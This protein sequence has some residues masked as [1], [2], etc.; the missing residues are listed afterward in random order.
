MAN[1][2]IVDDEKWICELISCSVPW[3]EMGMR[4]CAVAENGIEALEILK[5]QHIDI[6]ITDIRM[7][8]MDGIG[9]IKAARE[10]GYGGEFII[11]SG[12]QDFEYAQSAIKFN[13]RSYLVKPVDEEELIVLLYRIAMDLIENKRSEK[14]AEDV[15]ERLESTSK[16]IKEQL[17]RLLVK[18]ESAG[19][20]LGRVD[21]KRELGFAKSRCLC[22][23][24]QIDGPPGGGKTGA[25]RV[26]M[27]RLTERLGHM[28]STEGQL[29]ACYTDGTAATYILNTDDYG[30]TVDFLKNRLM[31]IKDISDAYPGY[32]LTIG[33]GNAVEGAAEI[34]SSHRSADAAV[35]YRLLAGANRVI[36]G[37]L[38]PLG[39]GAPGMNASMKKELR[40]L[41]EKM[42]F[43]GIKAFVHELFLSAGASALNPAALFELARELLLS[44]WEILSEMNYEPRAARSEV[45]KKIESASS[46]PLLAGYLEETVLTELDSFR[47]EKESELS[48]PVSLVK[49]YVEEN[50]NRPISLSDAAEHVF[51]NP[52]YLSRLFKAETGATFLDYLTGRRMEAAKALL[53]DGSVKPSKIPGLVGYIDARHYA[54]TFKKTVGLTPNEYRKL[55]T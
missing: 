6:V 44:L 27:N 2:M 42:D 54:K 12:Y 7:P 16:L 23:I 43:N 21:L 9:L 31:E 11:I 34:P 35:K 32:S 41:V 51:L 55:Y 39:K 26:L 15:K 14:D 46:L 30:E 8:G 18:E 40:L 10:A 1:V 17:A 22:A 53:K 48:R 36:E 5:A 45:F 28:L 25:A 37:N 49:A 47:S 33:V 19:E 20:L 50:Y 4:V 13:V 38:L 52:S 29:Y 3:P 24:L